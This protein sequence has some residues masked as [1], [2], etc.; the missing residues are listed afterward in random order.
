MKKWLL[1]SALLFVGVIFLVSCSTTG[2]GGG[3]I[4]VIGSFSWPQFA[5]FR[6]G[7]INF[8][9]PVSS[10]TGEAISGATVTV[11]NETTGAS[12]TLTYRGNGGYS[13][14]NI[15]PHVAGES[16]SV[17]ITTTDE[18]ITGGP[19]VTPDPIYSNLS[20]YMFATLPFTASWEVTQG[21]FEATHTRFIISSST[22][23]YQ[24]VVPNSQT[25]IQITSAEV[26][27]GNY[28]IMAFGVNPMNLSGAASGSICYVGGGN[29]VFYQQLVV[30]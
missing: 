28:A 22:E 26:S 11:S 5:L 7:S 14:S 25:S 30:Q 10:I 16:V 20:P 21:S 19:T 23:G 13:V 9:N 6:D 27:A 15:F 1:G 18:T 29:A 4:F 12:A 24:A 8:S 3:G 17:N 2:G